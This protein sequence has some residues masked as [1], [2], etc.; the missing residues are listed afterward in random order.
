[1]GTKLSNDLDQWRS[2]GPQRQVGETALRERLDLATVEVG[3][4]AGVLEAQP[5]VLNTEG[6]YRIGHLPTTDLDH[7]ERVNIGGGGLIQQITALPTGAGHDEN[8]GALLDV[9]RHRRG[10]LARLIVGMGVHGQES[11]LLSHTY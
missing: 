5:P 9:A 4:I 7:A 11:P 1:M 6:G 8:L 3:R 2:D 10:T